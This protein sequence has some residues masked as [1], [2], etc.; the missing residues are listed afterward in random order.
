[1]YV[2]LSFALCFFLSFS[3]L[4]K[5][6][7]GR[8]PDRLLNIRADTLILNVLSANDFDKETEISEIKNLYKL[9]VW[10]FSPGISYDFVRNRYYLTVSTSSL[11]NHFVSKK[12]EKRR[13]SAIERKYKAKQ[14]ADE[15]RVTNQLMSIQAEYQDIIMSKR[16]VLIEIDIFL[17]HQEQYSKNEIDTE[18]FLTHKRNIINVIKNHNSAVTNL[19]KEILN[20]SSICNTPLSADLSNLQFDLNFIEI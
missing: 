19:Y 7:E 10:H 20:L 2:R 3:L 17:L 6:Q 8:Q 11:V 15:L 9:S 5:S 4:A 1:M 13:V 14:L 16:I 12:Q 18:Q